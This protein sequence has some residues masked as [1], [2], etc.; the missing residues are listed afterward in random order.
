MFGVLIAYLAE[1]RPAV[2]TQRY[3]EV[4]GD[5]KQFIEFVG[6]HREPSRPSSQHEA[7]SQVVPVQA[8]FRPICNHT[9]IG[10]AKNGPI[11]LR[12]AFGFPECVLLFNARNRLTNRRCE[13][14]LGER[15]WVIN[16][17]NC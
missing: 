16:F 5:A 11:F 15:S 8:L 1:L 6:D 4:A 2:S 7:G 10:K 9:S 17:R 3:V 14:R 13:T 12:L